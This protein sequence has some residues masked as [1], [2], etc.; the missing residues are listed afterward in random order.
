MAHFREVGGSFSQSPWFIFPSRWLIS[1]KPVAHFPKVGDRFSQ[2]PQHRTGRPELVSQHWTAPELVSQQAVWGNISTSLLNGL[3]GRERLL[4]C[5]GCLRK[6][7]QGQSHKYKN[8]D[9]RD[10]KRGISIKQVQGRSNMFFMLVSVEH[11]HQQ[12]SSKNQIKRSME[13]WWLW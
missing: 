4:L 7:S 6:T 3:I 8:K 11:Y 2:S 9:A 12:P 1:P 10:T 13:R 5:H